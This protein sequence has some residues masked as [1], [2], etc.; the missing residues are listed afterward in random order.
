MK[1]QDLSLLQRAMGIV[2]IVSLAILLP[3]RRRR[4]YGGGSDTESWTPPSYGDPIQYNCDSVKL[5]GNNDAIRSYLMSIVFILG[6]NANF[7]DITSRLLKTLSPSCYFGFIN[8][9]LT[10]D[11]AILVYTVFNYF[12]IYFTVAESWDEY[13]DAKYQNKQKELLDFL[14]LKKDQNFQTTYLKIID[15]LNTERFYSIL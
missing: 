11:Q 4:R 8:K 5:I 13:D 15:K 6:K 7:V 12:S 2:G 9:N 14:G 1:H 10:A 3:S